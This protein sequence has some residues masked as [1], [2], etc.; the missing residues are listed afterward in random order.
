MENASK[1]LIIAG[2]IL[3]SIL[4]IS[5]GILIMNSTDGMQDSMQSSMS[6]Q[7]IEA[8]N[9]PFLTYES[10]SQTATNVKALL[11]K[12][13]ASNTT[14]DAESTSDQMFIELEAKIGDKEYNA[15]EI[16]SARAAVS[17]TKRYSVSCTVDGNTG[18]VD[19]V[20]ITTN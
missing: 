12:I 1:A 17:S 2:A 9:S 8:F 14:H 10:T 16:D 18:L 19:K 15:S 5:V 20:T 13:A 4:L 11:G 3:I 6:Q 7:E